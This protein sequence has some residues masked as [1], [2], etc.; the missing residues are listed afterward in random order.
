MSGALSGLK[1]LDFTALYPGPLATQWLAD[2]GADV[3]R[4]E[5]PDRPDLLRWMPPLDAGDG[6]GGEGKGAAWRAVNRNKRSIA[7]NLKAPAAREVVR[8]LVAQYDIVV[9]QFR[10]GVLDRLG[11]GFAALQ[12]LQP[13][14]IWCAISSYGQTGPWRDRPGHD[15]DFLATAG[16]AH[17]TGRP[18]HGPTPNAALQGDFG[19]GTFGAVA[20][21]LAAVVHRQ[22]TGEGQFVDVSMADGAL[23]M[24][25]LSVSAALAAGHDAGPAT[26]PLN[27]G[28]VY[29]YYATADGRYLAMGALEPKFWSLFCAAVG[30]PELE[31]EPAS[32]PAEIAALKAKVAAILAQH[33]L[34]HWQ[35][36]FADIDCCVEPVLTATEAVRHPQFAARGMI[37]TVP[38]EHGGL[39]RQV[40]SPVQFSA[41]PAVY[42]RT[43]VETGHDTDAV[44]A[45]AGFDAP[46]IAAL[47]DA[48]AI[49]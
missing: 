43:A 15:I 3:L 6:A 20:G 9:E 36:V 45:A 44:L 24:N 26:E 49:S 17:H 35:A 22:R 19:G 13:G 34:A 40:A 4:V 42:A 7:L 29:D 2:N 41:T 39:H 37:V 5:A 28:G 14:L 11:V 18:G 12:Q 16:V 27:G 32:A 30:A 31:L 10:P 8:R 46:A 1:I 25:L 48:G 38:D 23:W 33:P 21:I 47:R